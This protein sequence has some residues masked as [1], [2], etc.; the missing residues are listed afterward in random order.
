MEKGYCG[1]KTFHEE[2][3][4]PKPMFSIHGSGVFVGIEIGIAIEI[5]TPWLRGMK[6]LMRTTFLLQGRK[7][8]APTDPSISISIAIPISIWIFTRD[9]M[10]FTLPCFRFRAGRAYRASTRISESSFT[11]SPFSVAGSSRVITQNGQLV[12]S[13]P[14][15]LS[16]ASCT[17]ASLFRG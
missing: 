1:E 14:A 10:L 4:D 15:P 6:S 11:G 3:L 9:R 8:S 16:T 7:A 17:R 5:E 13:T 2:I 12:V